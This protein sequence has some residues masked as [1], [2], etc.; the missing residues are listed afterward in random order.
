VSDG[1]AR[2]SLLWG[3]LLHFSMLSMMAIGG[4]VTNLAPEIQRFVVDA[5]HWLTNQEFI[6]GF[7]IAQVAPGPNFL[8]VTLLGL[9]AAG[10]LGALTVTV[11]IVVPPAIFAMAAVRMST[12]KSLAGFGDLVKVALL[13]LAVGMLL[14]TGWTLTRAAVSN[15]QGVTLAI[16]TVAVL[17]RTKINP[18]WL[19]A[20]GALVGILGGW[21]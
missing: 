19:I 5:N 1:S 21:G 16:V 11:A 8:F 7:T 18:L 12:H 4:G 15:W 17:L 3:L 9:H 14:A 13:P 10:L 6:T 20:A 2:G